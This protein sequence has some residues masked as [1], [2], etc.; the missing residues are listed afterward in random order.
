L[1]I[2]G[3]SAFYHNSAASL[4]I[5]GELVGAIE[6]ER[7]SRK[8]FDASFP[9]LSLNNLLQENNL[10]PQDIDLVCYYEI[11]KDKLKRQFSMVKTIE[12]IPYSKFFNQYYSP[13]RNI[14]SYFGEEIKIEYSKHHMSHIAFSFYASGLKESTFLIA[15]AVGEEDSLAYGYIDSKGEIDYHTIK[16][17]HSVGMLY[18]TF[19]EYLGYRVNSDEYKVMGLAAYGEPKYLKKLEQLIE[20]I[21]LNEFALN[22]DYFEFNDYF[23]KKTFTKK[24]EELILLEPL[25][26]I[27]NVTQDY[28]NL[29][30]SIQS[31]LEKI[32]MLLFQ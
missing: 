27:S 25:K 1:N 24:L 11:P 9:E 15:D 8:K 2:I 3:I 5:N 4:F 12:S 18:S 28:K 20:N 19:T 31:L 26:D 14:K 21:N 32:I 13:E 29:A 30:A 6:E 7:I 10:T 22:L 16:F 17:P 23:H